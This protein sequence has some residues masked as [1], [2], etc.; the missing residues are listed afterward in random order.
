MKLNSKILIILTC[1]FLKNLNVINHTTI[2]QCTKVYVKTCVCCFT[3]SVLDWLQYH[4]SYTRYFVIALH[5]KMSQMST[6]DIKVGLLRSH[7]GSCA[8]ATEQQQVID[9][10]RVTVYSRF[11]TRNKKYRKKQL[12]M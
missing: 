11:F 1:S 4:L 2:E 3:N 7:C 9:F 10:I 8:L 12:L 6:R 5:C